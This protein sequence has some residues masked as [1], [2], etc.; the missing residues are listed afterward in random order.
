[1]ALSIGSRLGPYEIQSAIGAG[2]MGEVF[3]AR[4]TKLQ[5]DVAIKVLPDLFAT[6]PE[7]L[8]RFRREAQLLAALNHPHIAAIYGFEDSG[9]THALVLELVEGPTL[10]DRIARGPVPIDEA[11]PIAKQIADA[12]EAAHEQGIVHRDLKP[13]N[14]KLRPDGTVKVLDFGLAKAM[15]PA[16]ASNINVTMSPTLSLQ[17]TMGGMILGTAGYMSPEQA[18]GKPVDERAD[19]WA[20]GAVLFEMLTGSPPFPGEDISHIL[21]RVTERDPD[22]STL[23]TLP[24]AVGIVLRRCLT[25]DPRQ[26]MRDIGD[27]RLVLE[28]AFDTA[29]ATMPQTPPAPRRPLWR[30]VAFVGVPAL[31]V[32]GVLLGG[33]TWLTV[34]PAAPQPVRFAIVPPSTQPLTLQ[35]FQRDIAITPD[36]R[37]IVY[38][39]G[40]A[41]TQG[42]QLVVRSLDQL[43]ACVLPGISS[44]R[45][46]FI[47]PDGHWIGFFE[48]EAGGELKKVSILGGPPI[49]LCHF[50][51]N[52]LEASWGP[53]GTVIFA[54]SDRSTGLLSVNADGGEP[55]VLTKPD[56]SHGELDHVMP[57]M[58]P[59]GRAVLFT[60]LAVGSSSGSAQV[61]VLDLKSGQK[62]VLIRGG[63]DA[64]YVDTGHLVYAADGT[65]RAVRFDLG[66]LEV[67]SDP[68]PVVE[69][70]D[71]GDN[72]DGE[73]RPLEH[74]HPRPRIRRFALHRCAS[75]SGS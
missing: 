9:D 52:P 50:S 10:A 56:F 42:S 39:V 29:P 67:T 75:N 51:G 22:W 1:M 13:A 24:P 71:V 2:G 57:F 60:I 61:A 5:R 32:G 23:P 27:V 40:P 53:D 48:G 33:A 6:D 58:L 72:V 64:R 49:A 31:A 68:V 37:H 7:R 21:A 3:R 26:R 66:G 44:I 36:G 59:G 65:L 38:R 45:S 69:G 20:F 41:G 14:I 70:G 63:A 62:K 47:S 19:V 11:L 8:A 25:K 4:D 15:E 30:L 35:G 54:D 55:T 73:C 17:A 18:R 46:P 74:W 16:A 43:D 28:G 12:L 34:R